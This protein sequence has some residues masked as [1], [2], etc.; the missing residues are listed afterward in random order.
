MKSDFCATV[1]S[2]LQEVVPAVMVTKSS[3]S[4]PVCATYTLIEPVQP[5]VMF[6]D[7]ATRLTLAV[8]PLIVTGVVVAPVNVTV[9]PTVP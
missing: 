7:P 3:V 6:V 9:P 8:A 2:N 1:R 4:A 5:T